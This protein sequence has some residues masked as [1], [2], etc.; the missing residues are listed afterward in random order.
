MNTSIAET[1]SA[2]RRQSRILLGQGGVW[3]R[4]NCNTSR[5]RWPHLSA[6]V[7]AHWSQGQGGICDRS[8]C[9]TSRWPDLAAHL[10]LHVSHGQEGVCEPAH[11]CKIC[12]GRPSPAA[13]LQIHRTLLINK[14]INPP[15]ISRFS[16]LKQ[17]VLC[18]A[19]DAK[20][21]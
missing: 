2:K 6:S 9:S 8:H 7:H 16:T 3:D 10:H 5:R 19:Q 20:W 17:H 12:R 13:A 15:D 4:N 11:H 18:F 14:D 21:I 1:V